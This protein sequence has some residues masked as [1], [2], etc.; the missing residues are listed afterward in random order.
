M[1]TSSRLRRLRFGGDSRSYGCMAKASARSVVQ[2]RVGRKLRLVQNIR[3]RN[4]SGAVD[5]PRWPVGASSPISTL[6]PGCAFL[7]SLYPAS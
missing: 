7:I 6:A 5:R 3:R 2:R 1:F 4:A